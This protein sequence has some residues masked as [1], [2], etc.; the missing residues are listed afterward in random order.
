MTSTF[1]YVVIAIL[2]LQ[3]RVVEFTTE[4]MKS[5]EQ[6]LK[7]LRALDSQELLEL[8][9]KCGTKTSFKYH[10]FR[11]A[12]TPPEFIEILEEKGIRVCFEKLGVKQKIVP[13]SQG[14]P[15]KT[16][17]N[18]GDS[19]ENVYFSKSRQVC[20]LCEHAKWEENR[21]A[22]GYEPYT[23]RRKAKMR[24]A[25]GA[26]KKLFES[27]DY[28]SMHSAQGGRCAIC[29]KPERRR[30]KLGNTR[31][32]AIDHCHK[33]GR[34]RSLLCANCNTGLGLFLDDPDLLTKAAEYL[35]SHR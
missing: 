10:L 24:S 20:R 33:T 12:R 31:R 28:E 22:E 29:N 5:V 25:A 7:E 17:R 27:L 6:R 11:S 35:K 13:Y 19:E 14:G 4:I 30:S 23:L 34:V 2:L 9:S 32:L 18:C 26:R 16:C 3:G 1:G 15:P 21:E 8:M